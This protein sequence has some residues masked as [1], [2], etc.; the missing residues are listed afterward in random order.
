MQVQTRRDDSNP[1]DQGCTTSRILHFFPFFHGYHQKYRNTCEPA[2]YLLMFHII[3]SIDLFDYDWG[4]SVLS[5]VLHIFVCKWG[6]TRYAT[7]LG[8]DLHLLKGLRK[9]FKLCCRVRIEV[10]KVTKTFEN[11]EPN[12]VYFWWTISKIDH[13]EHLYLVCHTWCVTSAIFLLPEMHTSSLNYSNARQWYINQRNCFICFL[14]V[15][16]RAVFP[17]H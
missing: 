17:G 12:I 9:S 3:C 1:E 4:S 13:P 5:Q 16:N 14:E 8:T 10:W 7:E 2:S 6:R 11:G 15:H